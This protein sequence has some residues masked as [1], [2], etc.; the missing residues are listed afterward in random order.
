ML[1]WF[2]IKGSLFFYAL[3]SDASCRQL[4]DTAG[5]PQQQGAFMPAKTRTPRRAARTVF[6]LTPDELRELQSLNST[7][8]AL[9]PA[10][11]GSGGDCYD[12]E[13]RERYRYL[14]RTAKA[15]RSACVK[16]RRITAAVALHA[17]QTLYDP[18]TNAG[19]A[20]LVAPTNP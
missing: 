1:H 11:T 3:V 20:G 4:A 6:D 12:R 9:S 15:N 18:H 7:V 16:S 13:I 5:W 14:L 17:A 10:P 8:N 19:F 2:N